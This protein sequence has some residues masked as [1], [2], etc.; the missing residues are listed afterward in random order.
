M[1]PV[2]L[3]AALRGAPTRCAVAAALAVACA[4][5]CHTMV[6][7]GPAQLGSAEPPAR[8]WVTRADHSRILVESPRLAGDTLSGIVNGEQEQF[9]LSEATAVE[10]RESATG[11]TVAVAVLAGAVTLGTLVYLEHRP[12]VGNGTICS[13]GIMDL[14]IHNTLI[15]PCCIIQDSVPC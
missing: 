12:D 6:R 1:R 2:Q 8:V 11:R 9:V 5:G 7:V 4:I 15:T 13:D 3:S 14:G 10:T